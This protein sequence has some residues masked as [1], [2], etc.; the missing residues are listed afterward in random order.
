M[1]RFAMSGVVAFL[2]A[3]ALVAPPGRARGLS[4]RPRTR[5]YFI[6]ADGVT[7]DYVPGGA[8]RDRRHALRRYGVL[9]EGT[10]RAVSTVYKKVLYREYTDSTFRTL[11]P[12]P[13]EWAAPR[14]SR[15]TD[16]RGRRR[17]HSRRVPEQRASAIQRASARRVLQ[18][19][20]RGRA[21][22]RRHTGGDK[23]DDGVPPGRTYTMSGRCRTAR[24]PVRWTAAPSC[25]CIT[26]TWTRSA[27]S[28][29]ACSVR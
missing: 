25:G 19:E 20:L 11:K 29:R 7:W 14:L 21:V 24:V 10:P 12:R 6:A 18:E 17:H 15:A 23:A 4:P 28:T 16:S 3:A 5:T 22:Q 2:L 8:R 1:T 9:R 13:P 27:T 26:R